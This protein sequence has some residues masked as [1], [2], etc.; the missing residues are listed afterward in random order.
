MRLIITH[1]FSHGKDFLSETHHQELPLVHHLV[2]VCIKHIESN[3]K[4][5][6]GL[7]RT[8]RRAHRVSVC[9]CTCAL[10]AIL[11]PEIAQDEAAY[12]RDRR[13]KG[14]VGK[15]IRIMSFS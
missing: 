4:A 12:R 11:N 13:E 6:M 14:Q 2:A 10:K 15:S 5:S 9:M 1:K 7:W 8:E 3:L